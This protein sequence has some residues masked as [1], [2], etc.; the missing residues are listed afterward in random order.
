MR[1]S[2]K[3]FLFAKGYFVRE[4]DAGQRY[5]E[6]QPPVVVASLAKLFNIRVVTNQD[7]ANIDH[8]TVAK[9][10][11][12]VHVPAPFYRGFPFSVRELSLEKI[13]L[14]R[15]LHY[16]R[17]YGLGDF[18]SPGYSVFEDEVV[19]PC[20]DE[21]VEV[22]EV[23]IISEVEAVD[24]LRGIV[25]SL[26]AGSRPLGD[27]HYG[28]VRAFIEEYGYEVAACNCKDTACRLLLDTREP[29]LARLLKLSDVI[30]L[31][32]WLQ[33]L[34]Y[35]STDI[36]K[37][38]LR[39]RD[40]KL[41][42]A[43]L[44]AIFEEGPVDVRTCLEKKRLWKGLLHHLHYRPKN[45]A[46]AHF[47]HDIRNNEA[48]SVYS[49][50]ERLVNE[51][52]AETG[53]RDAA[54]L[55]RAE[56]GAGAVLRHLDYLLSMS[57]PFGDIDYILDQ[58]SSDNKVLLVQLLYH[59]ADGVSREPRT[60]RFQKLGMMRVHHEDARKS[61]K[62]RSFLNENLAMRASLRVLSELERACRGT[63][64]K[65]YVD[66]GMRRMALPLQEG[67]SMG[68]VGTLPRGSRLPIPAGKKIRAFT[69][70][71]GVDDIDLSA[72]AFIEDW[73]QVEFS[74]RTFAGGRSV[75]F[76]GDETSGFHGGSEYF[77]I[78]IDLFREEFGM[79]YLVFCDNVY[80]DALFNTCTCKAGFM[81]RD[82]EDTGE[83]FEPATVESSFPITC[84]STFA[85]LFAIDFD[86]RE[87]VWLNV[88]RDSRQHVAG[89]TPMAFLKGYLEAAS[90]INLH[91]FA[92][93][94]ATEVVDDPMQADVVFSDMDVPMRENAEH[95]RS[96]DTERIIE[97]LNS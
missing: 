3:D 61:I 7:W 64:G 34:T 47:L 39:N 86:R 55:L 69:Y 10:N 45:D 80:S 29:Q 90:V 83:V 65:V 41:L 16:V 89:E 12:G 92:C 87:V 85:Y 4:A 40:R 62:P 78:D 56:K 66:E 75:V 88:A 36:K 84:A 48:R 28:V 23:S 93:M 76:S 54:H 15:L 58:I 14:D 35:E 79:R 43:A 52:G 19:R 77:D 46:A 26:L 24:L 97:L 13:I 94:L 18:S 95:I 32:E 20:F 21:D 96:L 30:R 72:F 68:G 74:W 6:L 59:Y 44:D 70:W 50:F 37:L 8:V 60:F 67:A 82:V 63:L 1:D 27:I 11:L 73:G 22:R 9:R 57:W 51:G 5:V 33:L 42:T 2:L 31:V 49:E 71:E 38:N 81:M 25:D 91:D 53:T 17:T